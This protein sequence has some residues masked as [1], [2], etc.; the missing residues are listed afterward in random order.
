[1]ASNKRAGIEEDGPYP[2][3]R[4]KQTSSRTPITMSATPKKKVG[5]EQD[6]PYPVS[7]R[8]DVN[9][10][11]FLDLSGEI[12][13]EIYLAVLE[14]TGA[15]LTPSLRIAMPSSL[16]QASKQVHAQMLGQAMFCLT[17]QITD[18]N[19]TKLITFLN[20]LP[21]KDVGLLDKKGQKAE[22]KIELYLNSFWG[23][24]EEVKKG[25]K[26]W[27]N[28]FAIPAKR[29]SEL[30]IT[31]AWPYF[32]LEG[33]NR[34]EEEFRNRIRRLEAGVRKEEM[35]KIHRALIQKWREEY[36][37]RMEAANELVCTIP[38]AAFSFVSLQQHFAELCPH[39]KAS[40]KLMA[41]EP[42]SDDEA[43]SDDE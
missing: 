15:Y 7:T 19:F 18:F 21:E 24:G 12:Q 5:M 41:L 29:A 2:R 8:Q 22:L 32:T 4:K 33:L 40:A 37:E 38:S 3:H 25:L 6:G 17:A 13:N 16:S 11:S 42:P 14:D 30:E 1:M 34:V 10:I 39:C 36:A 43:W 23:L 28:R 27:L 9:R 31:Y 20:L 26:R 35:R